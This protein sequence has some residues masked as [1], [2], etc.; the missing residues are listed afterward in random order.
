MQKA[1][2]N[3]DDDDDHGG[4]DDDDVFP[5]ACIVSCATLTLV[6]L[7]N[8]SEAENVA[9][10]VR[11]RSTSFCVSSRWLQPFFTQWC[12]SAERKFCV[13]FCSS[14]KRVSS[15]L[16]CPFEFLYKGSAMRH[17]GRFL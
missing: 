8:A 10:P 7:R 11:R 2:Y 15:F 13:H 17:K 4:N 3:D 12:T 1:R 14:V 5:V 16:C 9:T 6:G